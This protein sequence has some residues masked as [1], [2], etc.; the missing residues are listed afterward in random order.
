MLLMQM[1]IVLIHKVK[2]LYQTMYCV[3]LCGYFRNIGIANYNGI[4]W[5]KILG[6]DPV[7]A[8]LLNL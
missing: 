2:C 5:T 8:A 7:C 6:N 4:N 3:K 1:I